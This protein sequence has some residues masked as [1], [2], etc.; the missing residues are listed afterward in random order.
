VARLGRAFGMNVLVWASEASRA[1]AREEGWTVA[2]SRAALYA[3][4]D[5]L[6]LHLP[7]T[8]KTRGCIG[9]RELGLMRAS[10]HLINTARG[11]LNPAIT[12][13]P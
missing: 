8:P 2:A 9:A 1:R 5:V 12:A 11:A 3:R 13:T 7:L 6:S 4:S 10:A